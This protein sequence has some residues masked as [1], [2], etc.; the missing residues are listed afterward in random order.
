[1][2]ELLTKFDELKNYAKNSKLGFKEAIV[3]YYKEVGEKQ[4][5]TV[6]EGSS[7][8][9]NTVNYGKVDLVWIEPNTVFCLEFGLLDDIYKH[10]FR[11]MQ[12]KPSMTVFILSGNSKC[13]PDKVK[14]I[15]E[16]TPELSAI[17]GKYAILD[18]TEGKV[19]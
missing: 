5:F 10:F 12:L 17:K 15:I 1:M 18:V 7:V 19:V 2:I 6:V 16:R 9:K 3:K 11:V 8:I 14:E 4:G 13:S